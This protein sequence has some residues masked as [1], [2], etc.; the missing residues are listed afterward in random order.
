MQAR[1]DVGLGNGK[2]ISLRGL[3]KGSDISDE[4]INEAKRSL[5][6]GIELDEPHQ[7]ERD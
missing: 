7:S 5:F 6:K 1:N 4:M 3:W 2:T